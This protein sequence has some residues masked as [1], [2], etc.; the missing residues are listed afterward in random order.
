MVSTG[1]LNRKIAIERNLAS[2]DIDGQM[3]DNWQRVGTTVWAKR[4]HVDGDERFTSDQFVAREQV[5]FIIRWSRRLADIGPT[6]RIVYPVKTSPSD[7]EVYDV[8]SVGEI[9]FRTWLRLV[10]ARRAE[11]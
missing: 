3:I 10:V 1:E 5:A 7:S 4:E 6:W 9:G 11:T 2:Q 8:L